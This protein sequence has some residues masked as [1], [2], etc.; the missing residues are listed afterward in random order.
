[1]AIG[2]HLLFGFKGKFGVHH[3]RI[4][5]TSLALRDEGGLSVSVISAR[6]NVRSYLFGRQIPTL[7]TYSQRLDSNSGADKVRNLDKVDKLMHT[8]T[9][10]KSATV[11]GQPTLCLEVK[12]NDPQLAGFANIFCYPAKEKQGIE[13]SFFG[14]DN[15][16][17][18]FYSS[19]DLVEN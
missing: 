5:V 19:L 9:I 8:S 18:E 17:S 4:P 6:G 3:V 2:Q 14:T 10:V 13:I 12:R 15:S 11:A 16:V 7:T 1:M